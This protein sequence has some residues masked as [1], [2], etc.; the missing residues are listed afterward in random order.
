MSKRFRIFGGLIFLAVIGLAA[1]FAWIDS[2]STLPVFSKKEMDDQEAKMSAQSGQTD[3]LM[4]SVLA[5]LDMSQNV[6]LAIGG[7]GLS[8]NDQNQKLGDLVTVE[9]TGAPGFSLVERQS[10]DAVLRELNLSLFGFVR[11]KD[12]V[13]A[14]KLL[15]ADWFLLGTEAKINGTNAIIARVVDARTGILRDVGIFPSYKP[16]V[17]L[18]ADLAKFLRQSRQDAASTKTREYLAIGAFEDLSVNNRQAD[19]PTHIRGYLTAAYQ[20]G[21]VTLLER[22]YV[23]FLL[24]EVRLDLAGLTEEDSTNPPPM[25]SAFWLVSGQYQSFETTNLQV[26][27]NL[28]VQ[29]A[30]GRPK[31]VTIQG[32]P[33]GALDRQIKTA[34]DDI[35][36]QDAGGIV[37]SRMSEVRAQMTLGKDL[38]RPYLGQLGGLELVYIQNNLY[39]D[40]LETARQKR[41]LEEAMRAFQTVLL[42]EPT[43]RLAKMY[44]AACLRKAPINQPDEARKF[45]QEI[46]EEPIQDQW[47]G[48]A[49]KALLLTFERGCWGGSTPENEARWFDSAFGQTTNLAAREFYRKHAESA[50]NEAMIRDDSSKAQAISESKLL[51]NITNSWLEQT[52]LG[53]PISEDAEIGEFVRTFGTN[54]AVAAARLGKLY[55]KLEAQVPAL[56]PYLLAQFVTVQVDTNAPIVGQFQKMVEQ[57]APHPDQIFMPDKFWWHI[58][59]AYKWSC[60]HKLYATA[61]GLLE[62]KMRAAVLY[63]KHIWGIKDDDKLGLAFA[64]VGSR[65]WQKALEIFETYSNRPVQMGNTGPWGQM[66][67]L[68]FPGKQ[69]EYCRLKLG[70]AAENNSKEFSMGKPLLCLCSPS[71]FIADADGL[72]IGIAGKLMYLDFELKTNLVVNLPMDAGTPITEICVSPDNVWIG[73][74]GDGLIVFDKHSQKCSRYSTADGLLMDKIFSM[75]LTENVLWIGY[76]TKFND[77]GVN[78]MEQDTGRSG[79]GGLGQ[80][81]LSSRKFKSFTL[82]MKEGTEALKYTSGN[83]V[84]ESASNPPRRAVRAV[85]A[86]TRGNIWFATDLHPLRSYRPGENVWTGINDVRWCTFLTSDTEN[87]YVGQYWNSMGTD[88]TGPLGVSVMN[89]KNGQ[90]RIL[91]ETGGL[92]RGAVTTLNLDGSTLWAGGMGYIALVDPARDKVLHFA[93]VPAKVVDRIQIGGG[94]VW[95]QFDWHLYRAPLS[96]MN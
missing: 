67:S 20:G 52:I 56:A 55:P 91:R 14:G 8:D 30:F 61:A 33:G 73:T 53:V 5:P 78:Y 27:L 86:D 94:Y 16:A 40:S 63:P 83:M 93:N 81:D 10:L 47:S 88:G 4:Q 64:Y 80:L 21:K 77:M 72:W 17:Q 1:L 34:I 13:R 19:F 51:T 68:V 12:A 35:L 23:D 38:I 3:L 49:Q 96:A 9:L 18:A 54:Q 32:L 74:G 84:L 59:P 36:S 75:N 7:L 62:G 43:N 46:I 79:A 90:W 11:A 24:R 85:R 41:N 50:N 2:E 31:N 60:E 26:E 57:S 45:Y 92:M 39:L 66:F 6:R 48:P 28:K 37:L 82:S 89:I 42:L 87:L 69:V 44:L 25:Q 22:E 58:W 15:K 70:L 29:R 65:E 95:A 76:G 71:T